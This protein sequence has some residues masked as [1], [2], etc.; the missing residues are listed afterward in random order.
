MKKP[1]VLGLVS[2]LVAATL[3]GCSGQMTQL[4]EEQAQQKENCAFMSQI[5]I[6]ADGLADCMEDFSAALD[7]QD[8][9]AMQLALESAQAQIEQLQALEAPQV[10]AGMQDKYVQGAQQLESAL[11]DYVA[12]YLAEADEE[13]GVSAGTVSNLRLAAIQQSYAAGMKLL[14]DADKLAAS[15]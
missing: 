6:A 3:C 1:V 5:H 14:Q 2:V 13:E 4:T 7:A 9:E 15:L 10:L 11:E 12:F 8:V